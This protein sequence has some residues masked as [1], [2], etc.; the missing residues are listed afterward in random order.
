MGRRGKGRF[1]WKPEVDLPPVDFEPPSE[2]LSAQVRAAFDAYIEESLEDAWVVKGLEGKWLDPLRPESL[3]AA[4][5]ELSRVGCASQRVQPILGMIGRGA[6]REARQALRTF[7]RHPE[8]SL[9]HL[10]RMLVL[11]EGWLTDPE[12]E[13][14]VLI[15]GFGR[16]I[17]PEID[18]RGWTP[19]LREMAAAVRC[20][21]VSPAGFEEARF[22]TTWADDFA[23]EVDRLW[24]LYAE[25]PRFLSLALGIAG[26]RYREW[27]PAGSV[28]RR[29][30]A[31]QIM[32]E[33][34]TPPETWL[35]RIWEVAL[36][37]RYEDRHVARTYLGV[38]SDVAPR[39]RELLASGPQARRRSAAEWLGQ[40][41]QPTEAIG[42]LRQAWESEKSQSVRTSLADALERHGEKLQLDLQPDEVVAL[43]K[44]AP[45]IPKAL[46]WFDFESAP[47]PRWAAADEP[48]PADVIRWIVLD[49]WRGREPRPS[50]E[51]QAVAATLDPA[52]RATLARYVL[53][54]W[55]GEDDR[56]L[57]KFFGLAAV[58]AALGD[59]ELVGFAESAVWQ[60][61]G[62]LTARCRALVRMFSFMNQHAA[63]RTL[64]G[65]R[66][67]MK[68][69]SVR[70]EAEV[71]VT[72]LAEKRGLTAQDLEDL[73]VPSLGFDAT[74]RRSLGEATVEWTDATQVQV[75]EGVADEKELRKLRRQ[76]S[77]AWKQQVRRLYDAMAVGQ[78]REVGEWRRSM[79]SHPL[80]GPL[81]H[82][83]IWQVEG[84][85]ASL[86]PVDDD[87]G[88]DASGQQVPLPSQGRVRVAHRL[89]LGD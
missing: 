6:A 76:V 22:D 39:L 20:C 40:F 80:L 50:L 77:K 41:G 86:I 27:P 83:L 21:G 10:V 8:L 81:A 37:S 33:M 35:E 43:A 59:R 28:G 67:S 84:A 51:L 42:I 52:S 48:V 69:A 75:V 9:I 87:H 17:L 57:A 64:L 36:D 73:A 16:M 4:W 63:L 5:A 65:L 34:P 1:S 71:C 54:Q 44:K 55:F 24:P 58:G 23:F 85:E 18:R 56:G 68:T 47:R 31:L 12:C 3:E 38:R 32:Q 7:L 79:R 78:T 66:A 19:G 14:G 26:Q 13:N 89:S 72:L 46:E 74:R 60:T 30:A 88:T 70:R 82:W 25:S 49:A 53:D 29:I 11:V 62:Y 2:P 45:K 15:S 61:S